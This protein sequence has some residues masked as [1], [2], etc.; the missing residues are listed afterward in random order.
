MLVCLFR[1]LNFQGENGASLR[2]RQKHGF[3]TFL[4][5]VKSGVSQ[6]RSSSLLGKCFEDKFFTTSLCVNGFVQFLINF[7]IFF[8]C[9]L[10]SAFSLFLTFRL[11][12]FTKIYL[13][14]LFHLRLICNSMFLICLWKSFLCRIRLCIAFFRSF[15]LYSIH[16]FFVNIRQLNINKFQENTKVLGIN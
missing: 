3:Y 5:V 13:S 2:T 7:L 6:R 10:R 9:V 15:S 14:K 8:W 4:K 12:I 11:S 1:F 16:I